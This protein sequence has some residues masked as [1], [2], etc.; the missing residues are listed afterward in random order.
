MPH[1]LMWHHLSDLTVTIMDAYLN[2]LSY[3]ETQKKQI[4]TLT[5][6]LHITGCPASL[7]R[8]NK[9]TQ[10]RSLHDVSAPLLF[11][12]VTPAPAETNLVRAGHISAGRGDRAG[13]RQPHQPSNSLVFRKAVVCAIQIDLLYVLREL[14]HRWRWSK[15]RG[16]HRRATDDAFRGVV[17]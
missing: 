12:W 6:N 13:G 4:I 5:H 7:W 16:S 9:I 11:T 3:P 10:S 8:V 2:S 14:F 17:L 1:T 15:Q